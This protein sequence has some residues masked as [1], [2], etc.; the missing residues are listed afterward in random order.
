M[1]GFKKKDEA[2]EAAAP[3]ALEVAEAPVEAPAE[4]PVEAPAEEV[5]AEAPAA[6]AA[7]QV[8]PEQVVDQRNGVIVQLQLQLAQ[9]RENSFRQEQ[10]VLQALA[11]A[12]KVLNESVRALAASRGIDVDDG[13]RWNF[14]L[15]TKEFSQL[16]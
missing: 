14:D 1:F 8:S 11:E 9:I 2:P 3:E 12:R 5:A 7:P 13:N 6:E 10:Q 15:A 16:S 4:A